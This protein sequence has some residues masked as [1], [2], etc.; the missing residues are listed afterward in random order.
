M[1][2]SRKWQP[3]P[4]F[5]PGESCEQ[6]NLSGYS[7]WSRPKSQMWLNYW[8]HTHIQPDQV[9]NHSLWTG[10]P[11]PSP[12][13]TGAYESCPFSSSKGGMCGSGLLLTSPCLMFK[14]VPRC[15]WPG[16]P[17]PGQ[18]LTYWDLSLNLGCTTLQAWLWNVVLPGFPF[19]DPWPYT[20]SWQ[21]LKNPVLFGLS[22][23][24]HGQWLCRLLTMAQPLPS[25]QW[26]GRPLLPTYWAGCIGQDLQ[27]P[28]RAWQA[29]A[30]PFACLASPYPCS[31]GQVLSHF[32]WWPGL[33][34][35]ETCQLVPNILSSDIIYPVGVLCSLSDFISGGRWVAHD[36][37]DKWY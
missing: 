32:R 9:I 5:L 30:T 28:N 20:G 16:L 26:T 37:C 33:I 22:H 4:S 25:P 18:A 31:P 2:W 12:G 24:S 1:P 13:C 6:K 34:L 17:H 19:Q 36:D 11:C 10:C 15:D 3:T 8:A 27:L 29:L 14:R 35:V 7:P 21:P 23:C